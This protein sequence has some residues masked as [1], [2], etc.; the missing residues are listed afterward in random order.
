MEDIA[1]KYLGVSS[2]LD[3][4]YIKRDI[5]FHLLCVY[6]YTVVVGSGWMLYICSCFWGCFQ[7]LII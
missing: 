2:F 7:Q 4:L 1:K 3:T 5:K 6:M